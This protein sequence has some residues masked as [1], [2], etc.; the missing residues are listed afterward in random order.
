MEGSICGSSQP[1]QLEGKWQT[2]ETD[3]GKLSRATERGVPASCLDG[4]TVRFGVTRI[5]LLIAFVALEVILG[6]KSI[7]IVSFTL[8]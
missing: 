5:V 2:E 3:L 6:V 8:L 4:V 1:G 7:V